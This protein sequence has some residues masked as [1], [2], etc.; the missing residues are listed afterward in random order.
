VSGESRALEAG[1]AVDT[2]FHGGTVHT[3]G[4]PITADILVS[5]EKVAGL[6]QPS[7][8]TPA[9]QTIDV[10]GLDVLPGV[11]DLHCHSRTPGKSHKEDFRTV[12]AAAAAGGIT[13]FV[14]MPNVDP[15]TVS[16]ES[17]AAKREM[18]ARDSIVDWGHFASASQPDTVADLAAA[19][20]TGFK[21]F[22]IGGGYPH[23]DR[24]AVVSDEALYRS[25]RAVAATGLPCLVHPFN[26]ALFN[27]FADEAIASGR[28]RTFETRTEIYTNRDV[29][30]RSA[31]ATALQMQRE[32][33]VR[34]QLLHTH[35]SGSLQL[36][37]QAKA[38]GQRV[39]VSLDP[40]YFHL[41]KEDMEKRG[42]FAQTGAWITADPVRMR[43]IWDSINDGTIDLIDSDHAPHTREEIEVALTD[44]WK[45]QGGKPQYDD[46]LSI[47]LND[48]SLGLLTLS[49]LVRVMSENPAR[50]IGVYPRKGALLPG[51]DADIVVV[52]MHRQWTIREEDLY[53][54]VKW[55]PYTGRTVT[56]VVEHTMVRGRIVAQDRKVVGEPGWGRYIAGVPQA[57][58][59]G[60]NYGSPGLALRRL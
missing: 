10:T 35:A 20:A 57:F 24:I 48:V 4:G 5:G 14:D 33:G 52:N 21:I 16:V 18:A 29:V 13:T 28:P 45:A 22:M 32:T 50:V 44:A 19:G 60:P 47:M 27:L 31:V 15:P 49:T 55:S 54:K 34:L 1:F 26:Q 41:T 25:F 46:M 43:L 39:T 53:T 11:I 17:L 56:G 40:K 9:R 58:V 6:V 37:R 3:P 30:W 51:S 59:E 8:P 7:D 42:P 38:A 36:L 12:S 23:D 2:R